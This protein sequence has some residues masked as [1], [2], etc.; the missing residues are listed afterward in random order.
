MS[1]NYEQQ[2]QSERHFFNNFFKTLEMDGSSFHQPL[3]DPPDIILNDEYNKKIGIEIR[4]LYNE[5]NLKGTIATFEKIITSSKKHF[6]TIS[7]QEICVSFH[8]TKSNKRLNENIEAIG[9]EIAYNILNHLEEYK[10]INRHSFVIDNPIKDFKVLEKVKLINCTSCSEKGWYYDPE[11]IYGSGLKQET[12]ANAI[13]QKNKVVPIWSELHDY[14]QKWLLLVETGV[15]SSVFSTHCE[16]DFDWSQ[17]TM[18]DKIY[19]FDDFMRRI[20]FCKERH[21]NNVI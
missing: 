9:E 14:H 5:K 19:I 11:L 13:N 15:P 3:L 18:F 2:K 8:F 10:R 21:Q 20:I 1:K 7:N 12:L 6:N 16:D 4:E 17:F